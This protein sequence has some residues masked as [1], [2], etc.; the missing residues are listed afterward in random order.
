M[1]HPICSGNYV[2]HT[3][4]IEELEV[5]VTS[6]IEMRVTGALIIG[7]Q[8]H[9]K[10]KAKKIVASKI[11]N[12]FPGL[13]VLE[14]S[15]QHE[16][17]CT[18]KSFF[19]HLLSQAGH[20]IINRR[21]D[22][23]ALRIQLYEYFKMIAGKNE[24]AWIVIFFDDAQLLHEDQYAWLMDIHNEMQKFGIHLGCYLFGQPE[25]LHQKIA[26]KQSNKYHL[27]ARFML[28]E[29]HFRGLRSLNDLEYC[30]HGFDMSE[31]PKASGISFSAHYFPK[32]FNAG[33]R[34]V[35]L[36]SY[37]W[38]AFVEIQD[39]NGGKKRMEI[40]MEFF[41]RT[42]ERIFLQY[43]NTPV[44]IDEITYRHIKNAIESTGYI[45]YLAGMPGK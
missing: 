5:Q 33:W 30:L 16:L 42:V 10:T 45:D 25:L 38:D 14:V 4:V 20:A 17:K 22:A 40:P 26:F 8:R 35:S 9:G 15:C 37:I 32:P 29:Y 27:V 21:K 28:H 19:I 41:T 34:A 13:N 12:K 36:S 43:A 3:K 7:K 1:N 6:W 23:Q 11:T 39:T 2:L 24:N 31:F 18:E 44:H